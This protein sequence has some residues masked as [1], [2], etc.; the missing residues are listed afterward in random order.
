MKYLAVVPIFVL[1]AG[2]APVRDD[3]SPPTSKR[4][5]PDDMDFSGFPAATEQPIAVSPAAFGLCAPGASPEEMKRHGPHFTPLIVVRTN[6]EAIEE[7]RARVA[8]MP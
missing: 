4:T 7:F 8:P 5:V 2:C 6:P 1:F 3:A